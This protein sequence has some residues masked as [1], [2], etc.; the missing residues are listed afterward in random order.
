MDE[1]PLENYITQEVPTPV[2]SDEIWK[3]ILDRS[4]IPDAVI[5]M[6]KGEVW[7]DG[8]KDG[9][10]YGKWIQLGDPLMNDIGIKFF[11]PILYSLVTTDKLTTFISE[12]EFN[13]LMREF[14]EMVIYVI[15]ERGNEFGI[16]ASNRDVVARLLEQYAVFA[17]S[18]SRKGTILNALKPSYTRSETYTPNKPQGGFKWPNFLGGT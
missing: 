1:K 18:A 9:I 17:Y 15:I 2:P 3:Q 4:K 7:E 12:E 8:L 11:T 16:P 6:F 13:R 5:H 10:P 14:M